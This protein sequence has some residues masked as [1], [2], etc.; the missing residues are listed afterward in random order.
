M[1]VA[2]RARA[3]D[4]RRRVD[5]FVVDQDLGF[6]GGSRRLVDR[7]V[8]RRGG[9]PVLSA[10][11]LI[12]I[13]A[14]AAFYAAQ[15]AWGVHTPI[16]FSEGGAIHFTWI[17]F[18]NIF[19]YLNLMLFPLQES[20]L[21][22]RWA[23]P[24]VQFIYDGR[25]VIRSLLTLAIVS[26]SFFGIVFGSKAIRFFIA[27][28]FIT[29]LPFTGVTSRGQWLNLQYLYLVSLGFCANISDHQSLQP[30]PIPPL[31]IEFSA[32]AFA[33]PPVKRLLTPCPNSWTSSGG[34]SATARAARP[35]TAAIVPI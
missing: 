11:I 27:W 4:V 30:S 26:F 33:G 35:T 10:D 19:R 6:C 8:G 25:T 31:W 13:A 20:E 28:T 1:D 7:D 24:F 32:L 18:K 21:L 29:V 3:R 34:R 17:S 9:R 15:R 12:L 16:A 23:D 5:R 2:A 22:R 14:G